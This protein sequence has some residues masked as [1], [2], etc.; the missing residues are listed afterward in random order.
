MTAAANNHN[1]QTCDMEP[2]TVSIIDIL[3]SQQPRGQIT[4]AA[5]RGMANSAIFNAVGK[6][7]ALAGMAIKHVGNGIDGYNTIKANFDAASHKKVAMELAGADADTL[8]HQIERSYQLYLALKAILT[9]EGEFNQPME[10]G[11]VIRLMQSGDS[12][13]SLED[14]AR[15]AALAETTVEELQ[16]RQK[17]QAKKTAKRL[18]DLRPLIEGLLEEIG[19]SG[20]NEDAIIA[21]MPVQMQWNLHRK[22]LEASE[23]QFSRITDSCVRAQSFRAS[24]LRREAEATLTIAKADL[25]VVTEAVEEFYKQHKD[26]IQL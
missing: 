9:D 4:I 21:D 20:M 17:Q 5:L 26:D 16:T 25:D 13:A 1:L 19:D 7:R 24:F 14:L 11:D 23:T 8:D 15:I 3:L 18:D 6:A 2:T 22:A 10:L 12:S